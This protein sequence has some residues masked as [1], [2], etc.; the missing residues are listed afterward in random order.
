MKDPKQSE[1]SLT[2][3]SQQVRVWKAALEKIKLVDVLDPPSQVYQFRFVPDEKLD[4][5]RLVRALRPD[6]DVWFRACVPKEL[7][8]DE[9]WRNLFYSLQCQLEEQVQSTENAVTRRI[10]SGQRPHDKVHTDEVSTLAKTDKAKGVNDIQIGVDEGEQNLVRNPRDQGRKLLQRKEDDLADVQELSRQVQSLGEEL[11]LARRRLL[12]RTQVVCRECGATA[13]VIDVVPESDV[14]ELSKCYLT[15]G[16]SFLTT[17]ALGLEQASV[18]QETASPTKRQIGGCAR[19][20]G[21]W[22]LSKDAQDFMQ[23][24]ESLKEQLRTQK[25]TRLADV[26]AQLAWIPDSDDQ[27]AMQGSWSCC[28]QGQFTGPGCGDKAEHVWEP[29]FR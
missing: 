8:R 24:E 29:V 4:H 13:R 17:V 1:S 25:T 7:A 22:I 9:F 21:T 10:Q 12:E 2:N 28:S 11:A 23:L 26:A 15:G 19:H 14:A 6:I 27:R 3:E 16:V 20:R 5:T 18:D